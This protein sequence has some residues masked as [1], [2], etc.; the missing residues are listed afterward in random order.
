MKRARKIAVATRNQRQT[1]EVTSPTPIT[2]PP[3]PQQVPTNQTE[4]G[5]DETG[6]EMD[7]G[8][9]REEKIQNYVLETKGLG[10]LREMAAS[11]LDGETEEQDD[12]Q[13]EEEVAKELEITLAEW[14][15]WYTPSVRISQ[16][17]KIKCQQ[18]ITDLINSSLYISEQEDGIGTS[19][20]SVIINSGDITLDWEELFET[21]PT[22]IQAL[23]VCL[24]Y[25]S[26]FIPAMVVKSFKTFSAKNILK[27]VSA[28]VIPVEW[29]A[30]IHGRKRHTRLTIPRGEIQFL[31]KKAAHLKRNTRDW[32]I[33]LLKPM[34]IT[35]V[36]DY[37]KEVKYHAKTGKIYM[38]GKAQNSTM[39]VEKIAAFTTEIGI[40]FYFY[41][42]TVLSQK[43]K[44][45][46]YL[47]SRLRA[48]NLCAQ[49]N[50]PSGSKTTSTLQEFWYFK[51]R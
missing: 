23:I 46:K 13:S 34:N 45:W 6:M 15:K 19:Y 22:R 12:I 47:H 40:L 20:T 44:L 33:Q 21:E 16:I 4:E 9:Y 18:F 10:N 5:L 32:W 17:Q 2:P 43:T 11:E 41:A 38:E 50:T 42:R 26:I 27:L 39:T 29:T 30:S 36:N 28:P 51:S 35:Y 3:S 24:V 48:L 8:R 7:W 1:E 49:N 25:A 37:G 14:E 31:E